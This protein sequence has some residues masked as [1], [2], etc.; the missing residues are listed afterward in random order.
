VAVSSPDPSRGEG[1]NISQNDVG[2]RGSS[3]ANRACRSSGDR[4]QA[5]IAGDPVNVVSARR[6][7]PYNF[8]DGIDSV[9]VDHN[10]VIG[11]ADSV[12]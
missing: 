8:L 11:A 7:G 5:R 10:V 2:E 9:G 3:N 1:G 12:E 4:F 6:A